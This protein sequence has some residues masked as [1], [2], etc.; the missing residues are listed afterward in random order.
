[1]TVKV[2]LVL[3][4]SRLHLF[5]IRKRAIRFPNNNKMIKTNN[6]VSRYFVKQTMDENKKVDILRKQNDFHTSIV[7][8]RELFT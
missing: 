2:I 6:V 4:Y 7:K 1:M 8:N 5:D 3:K